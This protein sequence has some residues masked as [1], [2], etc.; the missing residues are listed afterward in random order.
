MRVSILA[1]VGGSMPSH[2]V[3]S[4]GSVTDA[5]LQHGAEV[6]ALVRDPDTAAARALAGRGVELFVGDLT[7]SAS[8]DLLFAG[9]DGAF[10]MTTPR[11]GGTDQ[12]TATGI[13]IADAV[14]RADVPHL[15]FS[16]VG[17]AERKSGI[18][19]FE[20]KRLVEERIE[21][22]GIHHT[23]VRP[24][25]F[26]D[27]LAGYSTS[28]EGGQV[29]VRMAMPGDIPLQMISVRDIGKAV[30]AILLGKTAVEGGSVEIGGDS[31]TGDQIAEA[32][33]AQASLPAR[34]EE[35]PLAAVAS[36][37]DTAAM[38]QWF[39]ETPA[40]QA[41]FDA[42]RALVPDVLDFPGWLVASGWRP[43]V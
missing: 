13:T 11:E 27:N 19:H 4:A 8:L 35:L 6:R 42:T 1:V 25:F 5:Q 41:D 3:R 21:S 18:P 40:Y 15:V 26:M 9:V 31:L 17:G 2:L 39:A 23:F 24:V 29:V 10:G 37:G 22:L 36:F 7:D 20:S 34:Y 32:I 30:A 12:E 16:S 38:F 14:A 43:G 33:G 28:V